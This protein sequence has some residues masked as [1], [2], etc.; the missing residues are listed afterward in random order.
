MPRD[1]EPRYRAIAADLA[2]RIN[3]GQYAAGSALPAQRELSVRTQVTVQAEL[4]RTVELAGRVTADPN[5]GGAT[6]RR[7]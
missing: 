4:A 2:A 5:A 1:A 6:V 7:D 3:A